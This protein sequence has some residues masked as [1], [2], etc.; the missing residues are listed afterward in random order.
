MRS[1]LSE[2][3]L[4][5]Q[6]RDRPLGL[7]A[8]SVAAVATAVCAV[9]VVSSLYASG[10]WPNAAW[11]ALGSKQP[12]NLHCDSSWIVKLKCITIYK[13]LRFNENGDCKIN[14]KSHPKMSHKS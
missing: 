7:V 12:K 6:R 1:D 9:T 11:R 2:P 5:E 10:G 4:S 14:I 3:L 13:A 8:V